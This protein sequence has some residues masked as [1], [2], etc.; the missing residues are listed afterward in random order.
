MSGLQGHGHR[1]W[2]SVAGTTQ[3]LRLKGLCK[4]RKIPEW[5]K[6]RTAKLFT[7]LCNAKMLVP[8]TADTHTCKH[9]HKHTHTQWQPCFMFPS[10][11]SRFHNHFALWYCA[12]QK[13]SLFHFKKNL[14]VTLSERSVF[15]TCT[16]SLA[17]S[18]ECFLGQVPVPMCCCNL[19]TV[20][21]I[22]LDCSGNLS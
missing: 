19:L 9:T 1:Q 21:V 4:R 13:E 18:H 3:G 2:R 12:V 5:R 6:I 10:W 20:L 17:F 14:L 8:D 11:L 16:A 7:L 22:S 15:W